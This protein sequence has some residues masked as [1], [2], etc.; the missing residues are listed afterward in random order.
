MMR[1]ELQ[2]R[3]DSLIIMICEHHLLVRRCSHHVVLPH[4]TTLILYDGA[5]PVHRQHTSP[6]YVSGISGCISVRVIHNHLVWPVTRGGWWQSSM[7]KIKRKVLI[8]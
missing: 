6:V 2:K 3:I 1:F 7:K 8:V 5:V 4:L